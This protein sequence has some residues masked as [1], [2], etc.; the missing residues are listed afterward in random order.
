M[1]AL[2]RHLL[3]D[4]RR[5]SHLRP[6]VRR[7]N[8]GCR[9]RPGAD[10]R[11]PGGR[12]GA[13]DARRGL[14]LSLELRQGFVLVDRRGRLDLALERDFAVRPAGIGVLRGGAAR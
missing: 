1:L 13:V 5:R 9:H 8:D 11:R 14:R 12:F 7:R 4:D 2:E 3:A 10:R 6:F